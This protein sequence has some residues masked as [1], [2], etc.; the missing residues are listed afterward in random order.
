M[1]DKEKLEEFQKLTKPL[2]D[3]L[4]KNGHP[5]QRII[6]SFDGAELVEGVLGVPF[7]VKD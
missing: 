1:D 4:Q 2:N 3:W 6:I 5:H 7:K